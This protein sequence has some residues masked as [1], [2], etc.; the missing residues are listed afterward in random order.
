VIKERGESANLLFKRDAGLDANGM[1]IDVYLK[2]K[3]AG[4]QS[5]KSVIGDMSSPD[6]EVGEAARCT[7]FQVISRPTE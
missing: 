4:N 3:Q 5:V 2:I 6:G 7:L 1:H